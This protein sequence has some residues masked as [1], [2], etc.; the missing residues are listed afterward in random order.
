MST[1]AADIA[2]PGR[3]KAVEQTICVLR[4]DVLSGWSLNLTY[5]VR[6]LVCWLVSGSLGASGCS[7]S[8]RRNISQFVWLLH[9]GSAEVVCS[10]AACSTACCAVAA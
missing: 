6:W 8:L 3:S 4:L 1:A 9:G 5:V 7:T 10:D 2:K